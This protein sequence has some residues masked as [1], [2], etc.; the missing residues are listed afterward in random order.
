MFL[1]ANVLV[2]TAWIN[3]QLGVFNCIPGYPLD[4]G[5]ILRLAAE[6]VVSRVPI[7]DRHRVVRTV[8]TS[9]GLTMLAALLLIM[10]GPQLLG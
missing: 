1:A 10:F 4:G 7:G 5:R 9:I 2:W 6:S 8:T 3:S